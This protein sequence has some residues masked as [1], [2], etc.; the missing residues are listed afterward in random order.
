[1]TLEFP[2]VTESDF[3]HGL[4]CAT[5]HRVIGVG[6]PYEG[7]ITDVDDHGGIHTILTCVYCDE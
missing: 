2:V 6:R 7:R 4:R 3:P 1:M 5:C